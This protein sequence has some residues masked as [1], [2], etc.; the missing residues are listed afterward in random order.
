MPVATKRDNLKQVLFACG[1][2]IKK[3]SSGN[4]YITVLET[5]VPIE[6][7][8]NRVTDG[9]ITFDKKA[10][11]VDVTEHAFAKVDSVEE[12]TIQEGELS[13][14]KFITPKGYSV[15]NAAIVTFDKPFHS[16][17]VSG[18]EIL[19][20]EV[21]PNYV[22]VRATAGCTI[23]GKPYVHAKNVIYRNNDDIPVNNGEN[24]VT[25]EDATLVSLAN[26]S[27]V[28]ART[29]AYYGYANTVD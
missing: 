15:T 4:P 3:D 28:G 18:T 26:S 29:L 16:I 21:T 14:N 6:V 23:K 27:S 1:G 20:D 5:T 19:N 12:E 22:I 10:T 24:V 11:R 8:S 9:N 17:T 2:V 25:V 7:Q 13:G